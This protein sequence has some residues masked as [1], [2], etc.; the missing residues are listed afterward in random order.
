M[1]SQSKRI[2][3]RKINQTTERVSGIRPSRIAITQKETMMSVEKR[4]GQ[5]K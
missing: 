4:L 5:K 1:R 2:A 3:F